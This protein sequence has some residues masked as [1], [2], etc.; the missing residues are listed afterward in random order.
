M[1]GTKPRQLI[2]A[3]V[4]VFVAGDLQRHGYTKVLKIDKLS[5]ST[6]R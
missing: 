3:V 2:E 6:R 4:L 5:D 1:E